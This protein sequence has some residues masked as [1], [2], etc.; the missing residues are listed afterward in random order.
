MRAIPELSKEC[1]STLIGEYLVHDFSGAAFSS[2]ERG[3]G[4]IRFTCIWKVKGTRKNP[5]LHKVFV[6]GTRWELIDLPVPIPTLCTD[7][8]WVL[9]K[10][11]AELLIVSTP[12][13][14]SNTYLT[15]PKGS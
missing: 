7:S 5:R 15:L 1:L 8:W 3:G 9:E 6:G 4:L 10:T 14:S 2:Q 13:N 11:Q 12:T